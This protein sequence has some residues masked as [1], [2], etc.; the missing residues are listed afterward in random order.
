MQR[1]M[2]QGAR[3]GKCKVQQWDQYELPFSLTWGMNKHQVDATISLQKH[4]FFMLAASLTI[5]I[6]GKAKIALLT[7]L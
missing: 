2:T 1:E 3:E 6:M 5:K 7:V 4:L